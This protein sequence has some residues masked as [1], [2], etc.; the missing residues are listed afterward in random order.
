MLLYKYTSD[1]ITFKV[2]VCHQLQLLPI[3]SSKCF[4]LIYRTCYGK[5][6]TV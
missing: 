1:I 5:R 3:C 2:M 6:Q 4:E